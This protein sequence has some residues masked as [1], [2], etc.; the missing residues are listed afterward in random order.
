MDGKS[1]DITEE[2]LNKLREIIPEAFSEDKIDWEKSPLIIPDRG[3]SRERID[4]WF[5]KENFVPR[6]YSQVAGNEA[7]IVMVSLGFGIGLVPRL[8]LEKSPLYNQVKILDKA[9]EL[10]PFIIGLSTKKKSLTNP[11]I[12]AL[13]NIAEKN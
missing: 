2:K 6:I 3:I 1:L 9:P 8:V 12:K 4:Q 5:A 7:I 11:R 10:P 13:W